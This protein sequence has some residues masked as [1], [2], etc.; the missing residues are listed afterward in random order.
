MDT[1]SGFEI[2]GYT[3]YGSGL[4]ISL[5]SGDNLHSHLGEGST[6]KIVGANLGDSTTYYQGPQSA[7]SQGIAKPFKTRSDNYT[8]TSA[9]VGTGLTAPTDYGTPGASGF[10]RGSN[11]FVV[12]ETATTI[13][14]VVLDGELKV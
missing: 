6:L 8:A 2:G 1:A 14:S 13:T 9:V 4:N 10:V 12:G 3:N 11:G 7:D 5:F